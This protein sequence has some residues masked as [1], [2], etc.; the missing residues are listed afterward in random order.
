VFSSFNGADTLP[1][2]LDSLE[3]LEGPEGAWKAVAVD[4]GSTD[5]TPALLAERAARIPMTVIHEPRRGK[6]RS[7]NAALQHIEGDIVAFTD[8]DTILPAD[9][10]V[11]IRR[12]AEQ[13][14]G[15]D[16]FGGAIYPVWDVEPPDWV[17]RS[18]PR[19]AFGW[20]D[21]LE[22]P[23]NPG[24]VWGGSM[25]V[26]STVFRAMRF[27]EGI[28][29]DGTTDYATGSETEFAVR[30]ER[31]GH[32]CWHFL[33]PAVGHIIRAYQLEPNWLLGRAYRAARGRRRIFGSGKSR[34]PEW[35]SIP[36]RWFIATSLAVRARLFSD[37][38]AQFKATWHLAFVQGDIA[39]RRRIARNRRRSSSGS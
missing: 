22:G 37:V 15:Y 11:G 4:N 36:R 18:V 6:N 27:D 38:E 8:D 39:E 7:L 2:M 13:N 9:W 29:P 3:R 23:I 25:A 28:G 34:V 26:R 14:P 19:Y 30:A 10:L 35:L 32:R 16:I 24:C 20:T 21:F 33:A 5:D 12:Q 1:R 17:L 31:A